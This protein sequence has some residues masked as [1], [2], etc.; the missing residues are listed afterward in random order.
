MTDYVY[1]V[2]RRLHPEATVMGRKRLTAVRTYMRQRGGDEILKVERGVVE[3]WEDV[4][5]KEKE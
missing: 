3:A 2:T 5:E 4:T 1:R